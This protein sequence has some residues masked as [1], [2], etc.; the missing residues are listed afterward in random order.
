MSLFTILLILIFGLI[1]LGHQFEYL[2]SNTHLIASH[3]TVDN[4]VE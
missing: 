1:F 3:A 4:R 2:S